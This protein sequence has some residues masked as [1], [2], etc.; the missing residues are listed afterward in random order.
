MPRPLSGLHNNETPSSGSWIDATFNGCKGN[1]TIELHCISFDPKISKVQYYGAGRHKGYVIPRKDIKSHLIA[2]KETIKPDIVHLWGT[3]H[4]YMV[5]VINVFNGFPK[6]AYIQGVARNIAKNYMAGLSLC[7]RVKNIS[8]KDIYRLAWIGA[9]QKVMYKIAEREF[10]V[11][12]SCQAV[13]LENNWCEDQI[14]AINPN[15]TIFRSKLPLKDAFFAYKWSL[16]TMKP[17]T[18]FTNAG[19]YP[20]KGHHTLFEAMKYVVRK[21]PDTILYVPG[22]SRL[23]TGFKNWSRRSTYENILARMAKE[24]GIEKNIVYTGIL[25]SEQM[26]KKITECNVF[27]LPSWVENHSSSLLE[28]MVVGAPCAA[29]VAGGAISTIENGINGLAHN[30]QDAECLAGNII[31]IFEDND[32]ALKLSSNAR[33]L[34]EER[35]ADSGADMVNIY[36]RMLNLNK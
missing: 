30:P 23:G 34:H 17:H 21:Y 10:L 33:K 15:I 13:I 24:Y 5:D 7:D 9:R 19:G 4:D 25:N 16:T 14:K 22:H 26:A 11:L 29:S 12:N 20:I 31:R 35:S 28:A 6:V 27:A 3:E 1:E 2:L 36:N 32:L 18:I 8:L